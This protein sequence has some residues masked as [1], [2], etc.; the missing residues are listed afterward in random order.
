VPEFD[1]DL[2]EWVAAPAKIVFVVR[3][4]MAVMEGRIGS[5]TREAVE[6]YCAVLDSLK[7][8]AEKAIAEME[9]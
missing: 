1:K 4:A 2:V 8:A 9:C 6:L 5:T 7:R 3:L